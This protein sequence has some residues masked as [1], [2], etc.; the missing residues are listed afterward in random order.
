[1]RRIRRPAQELRATID[2]LPLEVRR[3]VLEGVKSHRIIAGAHADGEGG[4]CPMVA[5]EVVWPRIGPANIERAQEAARAWDRYA[6]ATNGWHPATKRHLLALRSM[7][8]ASILADSAQTE[9]PLS[10][11]IAEHERAS[12][13]RSS[14]DAQP[15]A[16]TERPTPHTARPVARPGCGRSR[17]W[18]P[19]RLP[20]GQRAELLRVR[21]GSTVSATNSR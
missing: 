21:T 3:A 13:L 16:H 19:A 9:M 20:A 7:L 15:T 6:D 10:A 2:L 8:E 11:A 12:E 17:R 4:V 18:R 1:M 5:A 14:A